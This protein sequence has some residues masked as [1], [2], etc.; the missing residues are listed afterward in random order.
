MRRTAAGY[1]IFGM[2]L[3]NIYGYRILEK[4]DR[5]ARSLAPWGHLGRSDSHLGGC[6]MGPSSTVVFDHDFVDQISAFCTWVLGDL[7]QNVWFTVA[8][9]HVHQSCIS[10]TGK[11]V[12][13]LIAVE[14]SQLLRLHRYGHLQQINRAHILG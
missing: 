2:F 5:Y 9:S 4:D 8:C 13:K 7:H 1:A 6:D 3:L 14:K 10:S 12:G 11:T